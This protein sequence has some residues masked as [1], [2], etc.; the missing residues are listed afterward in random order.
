MEPQP[1]GKETSGQRTRPGDLRLG[2]SIGRRPPRPDRRSFIGSALF[3]VLL[4][5]TIAVSTLLTSDREPEYE[6]FAVKIISPP[7]Q[8]Q[9][10]PEPA[11]PQEQPKIVAPPK[12]ETP[13]EQ[14]KPKETVVE[15]PKQ[16]TPPADTTPPVKAEPKP[17]AGNN[18]DSTS[19]GGEGL[20][21]DIPGQEFPFPE[22]LENIVRQMYRY[23][24]WEGSSSPSARVTF[25][26]NR[27]GSVSGL[28]L[29]ERSADWDFNTKVLSAVENAGKR[30]AFGPLPDGWVQDLLCVNFGFIPQGR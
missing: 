13:V 6:A 19:K 20:N 17:V 15:R 5:A 26:I 8:V 14:P 4:I 9:G 28:R 30:G 12:E 29:R 25:C 27:D 11:P 3:H 21:I 24:R 1:R 10:P 18:P 23:F 16:T 7:P 22:Y 2:R